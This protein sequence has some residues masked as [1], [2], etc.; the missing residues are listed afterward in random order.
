M[1][2]DKDELDGCVGMVV[3]VSW[4]VRKVVMVCFGFV[5]IR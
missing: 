5:S 1:F 3:V 4:G 2:D